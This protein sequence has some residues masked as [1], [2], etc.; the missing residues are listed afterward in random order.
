MG[1]GNDLSLVERT[2]MNA[3]S[4]HFKVGTFECI[5][6]NDGTLTYTEPASVYFINAPKDSLEQAL[7]EHHIEL[8]KWEE[9]ISPLPC[10]IIKAGDHLVLVDPGLGHADFGRMLEIFR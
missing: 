7:R 3:Q 9:W 1:I 6:V 2:L 8:D 5:V 4:Y 10:L